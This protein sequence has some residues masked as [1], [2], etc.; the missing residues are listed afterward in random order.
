[1]MTYCGTPTTGG[2][3]TWPTPRRWQQ[4]WDFIGS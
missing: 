3:N 1:M 4:L 2:N